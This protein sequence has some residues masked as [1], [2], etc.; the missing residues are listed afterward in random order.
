MIANLLMNIDCSLVI[1]G[2]VFTNP[3]SME[4]VDSNNFAHL[5]EISV[6]E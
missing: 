4:I 3:Y 5:I 1:K 2:I 6:S